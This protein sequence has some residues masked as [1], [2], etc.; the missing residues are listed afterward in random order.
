VGCLRDDFNAIWE[1]WLR[2]CAPLHAI[3]VRMR[4]F[5]L[6]FTYPV[7]PPGTRKFYIFPA[8][9]LHLKIVHP[10]CLCGYIQS[11][12]FCIVNFTNLLFA[13]KDF[14]ILLHK[15][16][17][18]QHVLR[19]QTLQKNKSSPFTYSKTRLVKMKGEVG[20]GYHARQMKNRNRMRL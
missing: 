12:S 9:S 2:V 7:L 5:F 10:R 6:L 13:W 18:H 1:W 17:L 15:N 16:I 11:P 4:P 8:D 14:P 20:E 19:L 3:I